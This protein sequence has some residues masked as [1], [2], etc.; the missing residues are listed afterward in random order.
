MRDVKKK[1]ADKVFRNYTRFGKTAIFVQRQGK[2]QFSERERTWTYVTRSK[3]LSARGFS[4]QSSFWAH[5]NFIAAPRAK[6][7]R[8]AYLRMQE[9]SRSCSKMRIWLAIFCAWER[10]LRPLLYP[11]KFVPLAVHF[12]TVF[13]C[14]SL[15]WGPR[16]AQ[17]NVTV[18]K[19]AQFG[20]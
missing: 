4:T 10:G 9:V 14:H 8:F 5:R 3:L 17:T 6:N 2:K 19:T 12:C 7:V 15:L 16:I 1:G 13:R 18:G 20:C 11:I